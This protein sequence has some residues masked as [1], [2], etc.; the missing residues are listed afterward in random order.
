MCSVQ[1]VVYSVLCVV[2]AVPLHA[3]GGGGEHGEA[4]GDLPLLLHRLQ[5]LLAAAHLDSKNWAF[6]VKFVREAIQK[7]IFSSSKG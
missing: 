1:C 3:V 5:V 2:C 7:R 4:A 6:M